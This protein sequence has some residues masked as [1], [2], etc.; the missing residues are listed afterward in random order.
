MML[1]NDSDLFGMNGI[2][3]SCVRSERHEFTGPV[4]KIN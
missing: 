4:Y 3:V 1:M 2:I